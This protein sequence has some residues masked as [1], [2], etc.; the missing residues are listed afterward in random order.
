MEAMLARDAD[1]AVALLDAHY[2]R[3][4]REIEEYASVFA[5]VGE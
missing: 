3:T 2:Q 5:Q 4:G 1:G